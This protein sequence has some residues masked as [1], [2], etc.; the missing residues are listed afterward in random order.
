L[1]YKGGSS[2]R[3]KGIPPEEDSERPKK[4]IQDREEKTLVGRREGREKEHESLF[5]LLLVA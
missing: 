2:P 4:R 5:F 3:E 1:S